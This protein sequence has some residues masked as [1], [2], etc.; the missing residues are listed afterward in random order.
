MRLGQEVAPL[1]EAEQQLVES[2]GVV[3]ELRVRVESVFVK[4]LDL[5]GLRGVDDELDIEIVAVV[6]VENLLQLKKGPCISIYYIALDR[7]SGKRWIFIK[8]IKPRST[9]LSNAIDKSQEYLYFP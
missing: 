5:V 7:Q 8:I 9:F 2:V 1:L 3:A 6:Q 4:W